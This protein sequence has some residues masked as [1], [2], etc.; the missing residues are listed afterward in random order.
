[1]APVAQAADVLVTALRV[2][3]DHLVLKAVGVRAVKEIAG[4][5]TSSSIV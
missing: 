5:P 2:E 3:I 1:M 4:P